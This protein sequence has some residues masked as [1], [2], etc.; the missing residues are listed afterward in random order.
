MRLALI[1]AA[2]L[3]AGILWRRALTDAALTLRPDDSDAVLDLQYDPR[4]SD[5]SRLG[6]L[7][8]GHRPR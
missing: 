2:L 6:G 7:H 4:P 3:V 5:L 8:N 1:L